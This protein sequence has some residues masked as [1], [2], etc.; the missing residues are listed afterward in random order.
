MK[1]RTLLIL[2]SLCVIGC[3][4]DDS[5]ST[6]GTEMS[7]AGTEM[8]TAGTEMATAGTEMAT[9]GTEMATAGT[10]MATAGWTE[11]N[12]LSTDLNMVEGSIASSLSTYCG[13]CGELEVCGDEIEPDEISED[14]AG[15]IFIE[16]SSEEL[17]GFESYVSCLLEEAEKSANCLNMLDACD[18]ED[19]E[20]C[21][22]SFNPESCIDLISSEYT[23]RID[24]ACLEGEEAYICG[25]GTEIDG[26]WVCDDEADCSGGEDEA[27]CD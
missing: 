11:P 1:T 8:A 4:K 14:D 18:Q 20:Q 26:S 27:D 6:A 13:M 21:L 7:T 16:S 24:I 2:L 22:D 10:E 15:C 3:E 23:S 12:E 9:A 17:N 25:D 5:E 19:A